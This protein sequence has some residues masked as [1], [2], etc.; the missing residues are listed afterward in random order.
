ME[1][2]AIKENL[3]KQGKE[4]LALIKEHDMGYETSIDI[5]DDAH[6]TNLKE[7]YLKTEEFIERYGLECHKERFGNLWLSN[8][9]RI[10][11]ERF[12]EALDIIEQ[13]KNK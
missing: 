4:L 8:G 10:N 11:K 2:S 9:N 3:L 13:I 1:F 12:K 5:I 6:L 7:W